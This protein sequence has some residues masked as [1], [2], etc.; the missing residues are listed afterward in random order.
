MRKPIYLYITPFF[1]SP[2]TWQGGFCLDA[3]RALQADGRYEIVVMTAEDFGGDYEI[4]GV[5]VFQFSRVK[6]GAWE[7]FE[8]LLIPWKN[9]LFFRKLASMGISPKDVA[10]CHVHDYLHYIPYALAIKK[11]NSNCLTIVHHHFAGYYSLEIG[12]LG[13]MPLWSD[14]LYLKI[15]KEFESVDAHVFI[16]EH[17]RS[18]YGRRI[19]FDTGN[20]LGLL[21]KQ[22]PWGGFYRDIKLKDSYV[23]YNGIDENVFSPKGRIRSDLARRFHIGCVGNFHPCKSQ[24]DLI[25]A[26]EIVV[27]LLPHARLSLVGNC[28]VEYDKCRQYVSDHGLEG[29][30][31]FIDPMPHYKLPEFYRGIDLFVMP[32]VNEGFCCVNVEAHACGAPF[33]SV[34]GLPMEEILDSEE[35]KEWLVPPHDVEALAEKI[36][37]FA[38]NPAVQR[39]KVDISSKLLATKY[40]D[41]LK[42]KEKET[43]AV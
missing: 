34:K 21:K 7:Y 35:R 43:F 2:R 39:L 15:R 29:I 11:I 38:K 25:R 19:D 27:R 32:S 31:S 42:K 13:L 20:D 41:W 37:K 28:G 1:P 36:V 9:R 14:L 18:C 16:S 8:T 40:C 26:M 6:I 17:C 10:V 3:V 5:K 12:S 22:L 4:E 33:I 30:V 24:M 23:W